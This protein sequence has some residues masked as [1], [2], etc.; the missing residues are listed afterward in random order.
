MNNWIIQGIPRFVLGGLLWF[1]GACIYAR[2]NAAIDCMLRGDSL[3]HSCPRCVSC[4]HRLPWRNRIPV[5]GW[6]L[7]GGR[8][9]TCG[10]K[11]SVRYPWMEGLGGCA[12][13]LCA[14]RIG[15][16]ERAFT[17]FVFF[18]VLTAVALVDIKTMEIP[19]GFSA[20]ILAVGMI[21]LVTMPELS[22]GE[23]I[24]G[25]CSVSVPLLLITLWIPGAF[26]GGD[27]KLM[28]AS[29]LLLGWKLSLVALFLAI[30]GGGLYGVY[31]LGFGK[32]GRKEHFAFGPFLCVGM[33]IALLWGEALVGWY[34]SLYGL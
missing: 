25:V 19:N 9:R 22:A 12:A 8:C 30:L 4:G 21:S 29:G 11:L 34:L 14:W 28:G 20:A 26:G 31:L 7:S 2:L 3:L 32:K 6:L 23:R 1:S 17:I 10:G 24:L 18:S 15:C 13:L 5:F 33:A 16:N 27:I